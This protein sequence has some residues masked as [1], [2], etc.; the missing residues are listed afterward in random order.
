M[1]V[2]F[3]NNASTTVATGINTSATSLTV[4]SASAFPQLAGA[5]DYCYL[6]IQQ[7]TGTGREVVK[8]TALSTN[9]F[10]ITR[11]QDGTSAGT[12]SAGDIVELRM[13]AALLTDVID[14]ATVDGVK[15][16]FQYTPT[17]GQTVFSGADNS[18]NTLVINQSGLVNT[19]MNGVRLV[20][21]TDYTVS[22]ANNTITLTT[23]AT[24]S[25][26]IDI[27]VYGNFTGQSGAAVAI[28]GGSI[29]GTAITAT[30]LGASGT[31]TLNTFV[32]NNSTIS[33]GTINNVAIG[34]TTQAAG[35]FSDLTAT[36]SLQVPAG[37]TAQRPS[38]PAAGS[39][40]YNTTSSQF[41]GYS[42]SWGAISGGGGG[43]GAT[44]A[45]SV[46]S[47]TANGS[48]TAFAISQSVSSENNLIVFIEGIFQ[49]QD[50]Y[51]L[52][53][54]TLTFVSAPANGNKILIYS[55]AAAVSGSNL[56]LDSMT[57]D[58]S[59]TT[60]ALSIAPINENNCFVT[61][62][63]VYQSKSNY[64]VSG[65]TLTFSTAPPA[66]SAVEV[67]TLTQTD[68]NVPVDNTITSAKLSGDLTTPGALAVTGALTSPSATFTS[69]VGIDG[70]TSPNADLH[71]G[72]ASAV[73]DATN[74]ALQFGGSTTYRLG[75]YTDAEGGYIEN[76]NGDDGL[77][78][79]VKTVGEAM[80]VDGG[81]GNV[82]I[83]LVPTS[84]FHVKGGADTIARIEPSSN[85]GKATL[86]VSSSGSGDGGVQYNA[87]NNIMSLFAY[88]GMRFHVGTGNISGGYP[89]NEAMRI[90]AAGEFCVGGVINGGLTDNG[91]FV[92][93]TDG[94][95]VYSV[96]SSTN[97]S[98]YHVY[99][100]GGGAYKFYVTYSG[101]IKAV[102]T[103]VSGISDIRWK[104]NIRDLDD[105]LSKVMQLQP[106]KFDWKK[107]KGKDVTNDRGFIAQEFEAVF[108]D[109]ID[110]WID[111][112]PEGEEPYK[113]VRAD[114]IP[115]L[116]KAIQEQQATIESQATAI[117]DL[118]TRLTAL[119]NN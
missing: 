36:T 1:T 33:G 112:A 28:T 6:T 113:A 83:G 98:T 11:A 63:G 44:S 34:G 52:S 14:A 76:K 58:G 49:Q 7:A 86:L 8:A 4:A 12:W 75:M 61:I 17:A 48:T 72:T 65:S 46:D 116:V 16:N 54:N 88:G 10:T 84:K 31:A 97:S 59:D 99:D 43:G 35:S 119:E 85:T 89:A 70:Q 3:T 74:P 80:R 96:N 60:L 95:N 15:S 106:R 114:L 20:Q 79:R 18:S 29:T 81:T 73:G 24:T 51:V 38:S 41:E 93:G 104:E 94:I 66:G 45:F 118:T 67:M 30:T 77:I 115:T 111:P 23:G 107:G 50:A 53:G 25:D 103:T 108:P 71:I 110:E 62:D 2:K 117:T 90:T 102:N 42:S 26:I 87:S 22:A 57:G 13:T 27:E 109:L 39:F 5:D 68:I 37:T 82:G 105:G 21:G 101:T 91:F 92:G 64:S 78:F 19:Y 55:I 47:Y 9:T 40:R 32:S 69:N 100:N 56:N